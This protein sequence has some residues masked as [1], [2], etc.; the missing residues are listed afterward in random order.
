MG[1]PPARGLS[2][3]GQ[4]FARLLAHPDADDRLFDEVYCAAFQLLDRLWL[5]EGATYMEF[6][7]VMDKVKAE[8]SR[9]LL[10]SLERGS[11]SE[12]DS[13]AANL[14]DLLADD[15]SSTYVPPVPVL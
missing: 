8:I 7:A 12:G 15:D 9:V 10:E 11:G 13:P 3:E 6:N 5:R 1:R 4:A 2:P 14:R